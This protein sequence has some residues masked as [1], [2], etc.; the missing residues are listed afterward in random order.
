MRHDLLN[1][2]VV[3][4]EMGI[5]DVD[6]GRLQL[7][8]TCLKGDSHALCT[9]PSVVGL[10]HLAHLTFVVEGMQPEGVFGRQNHL[11]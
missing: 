2:S 11:V 7:L 1:G 3:G 4:P 6:V 9:V 5:E 10:D 8:E